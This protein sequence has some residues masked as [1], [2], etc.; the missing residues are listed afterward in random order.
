MRFLFIGNFIPPYEEESLHNLTLLHQLQ[1]EGHTCN[2]INIE[3]LSGEK[4]SLAK[5]NTGIVFVKS[6]TGFIF[7]VIRF[8][9]N[10]NV[11]HFL[12]KGYTRPGLMKLWTAAFLGKIMLKKVIITI[13][14]EMFSIFGQLRSKMGGQQLLHLSFSMAK[15]VICGDTHTHEIASLHYRDKNKFTTIP[16]FFFFPEDTETSKVTFSKIKDKKKNILFSGVKYPSL[17]FEVLNGL[18]NNNFNPETGIVISISEQKAKQLQHVLEEAHS[19]SIDNIVFVW[20]SD[21]RM[22]SLAYARADLVIRTL[23]CDC[24]QL[25]NN[26]SITVKKPKLSL[27]RIHFPDSLILIK[28]GQTVETISYTISKILTEITDKLPLDE[29]DYY[30]KIKEIY[31]I[32]K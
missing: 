26:I 14:P 25:F 21:V 3:E 13:H 8:G 12:T 24:K 22:M 11:I 9:F 30:R 2:V 6:Y 32:G 16:P 17:I 19:R 20:P 31:N 7:K 29:E 4:A 5:Q 10:C 1:Q 18:L 28:E 23:S 15:K 27:N